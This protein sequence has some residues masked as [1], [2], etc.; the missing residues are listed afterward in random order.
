MCKLEAGFE[1]RS[2]FF[3]LRFVVVLRSYLC[4]LAFDAS[5]ARV[6]NVRRDKLPLPGPPTHRCHWSLLRRTPCPGSSHIA[7]PVL[8]RQ[9]QRSSYW[10]LLSPGRTLTRSLLAHR[11]FDRHDAQL[12]LSFLYCG[13]R[14]IAV[15]LRLQ[16]ITTK[17]NRALG[18]KDVPDVKPLS[19]FCCSK[20]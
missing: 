20:T 5:I 18:R 11:P 1:N 9:C 19:F 15:G 12:I 13:K 16:R 14:R 17:P 10:S 4:G 2:L 6:E 7:Q 8:G 3:C